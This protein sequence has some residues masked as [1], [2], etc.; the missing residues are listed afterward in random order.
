M[1]L[2]HFGEITFLGEYYFWY[3]ISAA[4]TYWIL[5]EILGYVIGS[6]WVNPCWCFDNIDL[7]SLVVSFTPIW[8]WL[9]ESEDFALNW[10]R[11]GGF[12][13]QKRRF[14]WLDTTVLCIAGAVLL[15][16][17]L[18]V[19]RG[20]VQS[21]CID[22]YNVF[23]LDFSTFVVQGGDVRSWLHYCR[24]QLC[25]GL[26][27]VNCTFMPTSQLCLN[28]AVI[29]H[30]MEFSFLF[31][32][33][34]I[35]R[36]THVQFVHARAFCWVLCSRWSIYYSMRWVLHW[37]FVQYHSWCC[38]F[39]SF[40]DWALLSLAF[41]VSCTDSDFC[42]GYELVE[43]PDCSSALLIAVHLDLLDICSILL[44]MKC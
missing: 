13:V 22:N 37:I 2:C 32:R 40:E 1:P 29:D 14:V 34:F 16:L 43:D 20:L 41:E 24:G 12:Q 5:E 38:D 35:V 44:H 25:R 18:L 19:Q 31:T 30:V 21:C 27:S 11:G 8:S 26:Y 39:M 15:L 36:D 3:M 9:I 23:V 17:S 4:E 6:L 7:V 42:W 33:Q 10:V 28:G